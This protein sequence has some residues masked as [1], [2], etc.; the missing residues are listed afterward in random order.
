MRQR[1]R[2]ARID[3]K[4]VGVDVASGNYTRCSNRNRSGGINV[5]GGN[6]VRQIVVKVLMR[7]DFPYRNDIVTADEL[8]IISEFCG[9]IMYLSGFCFIASNDKYE[10]A[11]SLC[12]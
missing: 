1:A 12:F 2:R 6:G 5:A 9:F 8:M 4:A 7:D 11:L 3:G 10:Q